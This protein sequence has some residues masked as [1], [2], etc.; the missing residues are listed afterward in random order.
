MFI[1]WFNIHPFVYVI[2][3]GGGGSIDEIDGVNLIF[4]PKETKPY[5][6]YSCRI[7]WGKCIN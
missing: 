3:V 4:H 6:S 5:S 1:I 7:L 2:D